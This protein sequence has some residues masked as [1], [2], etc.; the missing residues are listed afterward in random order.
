MPIINTPKSEYAQLCSMLTVTGLCEAMGDSAVPYLVPSLELALELASAKA[1][2]VREN[3]ETCASALMKLLAPALGFVL[4]ILFRS[5]Q[6]EKPWTTRALGLGLLSQAKAVCPAQLAK[7]LPAIIPELTPCMTDT[8]KEVKKAAKQAMD[9]AV[10]VVHN[11]DI[12]PVLEDLV[13]CITKPQQVPELMH[14]LGGVVFVQTI[15]SGALAV[16][17]PLLVRGLREKTT[18]VKRI[19]AVVIEN[20][21]K[22]VENPI[23]AAPFLP[24]LLPALEKAADSVSDPEARAVCDRALKQLT[25]LHNDIL[26]VGDV[27]KTDVTLVAQVLREELKLGGSVPGEFETSLD[28]LSALLGNMVDCSVRD[29]AAW[30]AALPPYLSAFVST[31]A[32]QAATPAIVARCVAMIKVVPEAEEEVDDKEVL[33]DVEFTLAYGTK[34]LLHNT[35]LKLKRGNRYGLLGSNDCGKTTLM[36][37]ISENQIE[38]FPPATEL[39]TVFVEADILGELSHLTCTDYVLADE[40]IQVFH[41]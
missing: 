33:A 10:S 40:R 37:S 41:P 4:P 6:Q 27:G 16:M 7:C 26:K 22:L 30:A 9:D 32:V 39:R 19:T 20:M 21:S 34:I 28:F 2:A 12:S 8:K 5:I 23:E 36:R 35:K 31:A 11:S 15:D 38:G 17:V 1:D 18:T 29:K 13:L 24:L 25:R 14:K 3:A